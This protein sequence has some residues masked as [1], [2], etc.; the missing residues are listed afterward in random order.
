MASDRSDGI[1]GAALGIVVENHA[2]PRFR[3][4]TGATGQM[5]ELC[6]LLAERGFTPTVVADP[7]QASVRGA[8][9]DWAT[10][11]S[12]TGDRGPV[13]VLWS[14]HGVRDG[15]DL[16]LV[17]HDTADPEYADET[18]S[19]ASLT[20]AALRSRA[21][22]MLL[23]IDTCH[24]GA[25][26]L[27]SLETAFARLSARNLPP[28]R[29]AWLGVIASSRPQ[30]KAEAS[31]ILL[32]TLTRVLRE[33]PR[34]EDYRHE[35]SSRNGRVSG[36]T[37]INTV[38]AQWPEEVGHRPVPA[39][40]GEPR[41]MFDN[42]LR[43][44]VREP[45]LVEHLV[46]ASRGAAR[47][48]EGWFFSGR[49]RVL[50]EITSWLSAR[51]PG[52][53]LVTGSA[54]S[55]K[56]AVLGRIATLSD[57]SHRADIVAHGAL[58]PED[59]DPGEG[60]V[61][62]SLHLR[63]FTVQQL[64]EAI[65]DRLRLPVPE[66][67]AALIAA[68][69]K[70]W[71]DTGTR[72]LPALVLDGLDEAA[73]DAAHPIVERLLA[74]LSRMTCVL[75]GSRDRPFRPVQDPAERLDQAVSRLLDVRARAVDLNGEADTADDIRRYC[76]RRLLARHL[77]TDEASTAADLITGRA[78]PHAGGFLFARMAVD[79]VLRRFAA[80]GPED[81]AED[82][83]DAI[84]S[85][86]SA[87]F[88]EDLETGPRREQNGVL[89]PNAAKD[90][91]SAL[92]WS[93]GNGMPARGVWEAA[94]SAL[95]QDG[96][97]YGPGDVDWL[98]NTYGRYVVEDTD[99]VQAVY[100]L[101][102]RE[103]VSHLRHSGEGSHA[104]Y[105]VARAMIDLLR[106]QTADASLMT[107][108][109]PYLRAAL[110]HHAAVAGGR[111]IT[112]IREL[113]GLREEVFRADLAGVL[114][115]VALSRSGEGR[116]RQA[117]ALAQE[118]TDLY[119]LE[120]QGDPHSCLPLLAG[121]LNILSALQTDIGD[122]Q[123]ALATITEATGLYRALAAD[124]PAAH[125]PDLAH[126]LTNFAGAQDRTG[127]S[128]GALTTCTEATDLYRSVA[129]GNPSAYLPYLTL[130]LSNLAA[131][132]AGTGDRQGALAT[133]TEATGLCRALAADN[134]PAHLPKLAGVL[135]NLASF[136]AGTRD[137]R[138]ALATSTE[139][140]GLYRMLADKNPAAYLPDLAGALN[141]LAS[142]Q[143]GTGDRQHA[144]ATITE[145]VTIQRRLTR[146]NPVAHLS[147]L[148]K[149]L[150]NLAGRQC[151]T[152]DRQG[153]LV[154]VTE[155]VTIHRRLTKDNPAV[156]LPDLA[157]SLSNLAATQHGIGDA[158]GAL[159]T[160]T[161]A[162]GLCR[163]LVDSNG[164]AHLP[165]L[166]TSLIN[167]AAFR[168]GTGDSRGALTASFEAADL[169]RTL[170]DGNPAAYLPSLAGALHN[171]A[172]AQAE[173]RD[174]QGAMATIS[175][176]VA[177]RRRL[178]RDN[179]SAYLPDLAKTLHNLAAFQLETGDGQ[180]A[181]TI[182]VEAV[183]LHHTLAD[184][185]PA[186]HLPN[187]ALSLDCLAVIQEETGDVQAALVTS[188][189]AI[190][191]IRTLAESNP[192][193]HL[194]DLVRAL[195][196]RSSCRA[197]TGDPSGAVT[198]IAEATD[199][200]LSLAR[201]PATH[202]RLIAAT[203]ENLSRS[204]PAHDTL[205]AYTR[206]EEALGGHP[207]AVRRLTLQR[208]EFET[209]STDPAVGLHT[210]ISLARDSTPAQVPDQF[211]VH[212]RQLLRVQCRTDSRRASLAAGLWRDVTG[213]GLPSW[214]TLPQGA[215]DL[216][217]EWID[218]PSWTASRAFWDAHAEEL[219]SP[220]T[221][222][223]LEEL[224]VIF[225][226]A[227]EHLR[228]AR[229]AE[230]GDPDEAF[231]PYITGELLDAWGDL[232]T[233][234]ESRSYLAE[235]ATA[236]LHPQ[237]LTLLGSDPESPWAALRF[238]VLSLARADGI[239]AA[240]QYVEDRPAAGERLR[241]LMAAPEIDTRL[242]RGLSMLELLVGQE[243]FAGAVHL[244]LAAVL[245]GVPPPP[246]PR[247]PATPAQRDRVIAEIAGLVG[248]QPRHAP[249]LGA[250]IQDILAAAGN[251]PADD[252]G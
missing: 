189:K 145:A 54:G 230:S 248:R 152:G 131:F 109:N 176:A 18:Y 157:A 1:R 236:L 130:S 17:L 21:D 100:R 247:P 199:L 187:L 242:L 110:V 99:G 7:G 174:W 200:C 156:H 193:A 244:A 97:V 219:R 223:A 252:P 188:T 178:S 45:D 50:G 25:G 77:A 90:L 103:F 164:E 206:V 73:P 180:G 147:V 194:A 232:T 233:L 137:T 177:I 201:D 81:R 191:L 76:L 133:I 125:L 28:G 190:G 106:E 239:P 126:S 209:A 32:G 116:D 202:G 113:A 142:F 78:S 39:M 161:E 82:W 213:A 150:N 120:A 217:M 60:S 91:L 57:P 124:N 220:E 205:M 75:L 166:A 218:C 146:D 14:G 65:A 108:T 20:E 215:L 49:R 94:A 211:T 67:P 85:S 40:F 221:E 114:C 87:A 98:L 134:P 101:Y 51:Q 121:T 29:S 24:A 165:D 183:G 225:P 234:E 96:V 169:Y 69:E 196:N 5:R 117:V 89:L 204:A 222:T 74:P 185:N 9:R 226:E 11:W 19:A 144:L 6:G 184:G 31:G 10:D 192:A 70:H 181:L 15:R 66:T 129:D 140:T 167:H 163:D 3:T 41:L 208:A 227:V 107:N 214:W 224:A 139:A 33:G 119:R 44:D 112:L 26:V 4:L 111:G 195:G 83:E 93:A 30:E 170:A 34:S 179:P 47:D 38:L 59:P 182:A 52:L 53:F 48:D 243:S 203:L 153:A 88:T 149:S 159:A 198:D 175:E 12:A 72:G 212:A 84:P 36:A 237:A 168:A 68:V 105:E 207:E 127:D 37:V 238:A 154:T 8:V 102:H 56:S 186:A 55:G 22:Q 158:H 16:R 63:G 80:S 136:Q 135:N 148:A 245:D 251:A 143:A 64:A 27:E 79:S 210:L 86:I 118:A 155:A 35:W 46:Q 92:A 160:S 13:I 240:Y 62:V 138:G 228:I 71:P 104:A 61:D 249:A 197:K 132:Q 246:G 122:H 241:H 141:N 250:L 229:E 123:G 151:E 231:R 58:A 171:L 42:P 235:H 128:E 173:G 2:S 115:E 95:N 43:R 216:A 162:I 23:I 172:A